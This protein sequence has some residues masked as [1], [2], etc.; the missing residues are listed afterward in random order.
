MQLKD[1]MWLINRNRYSRWAIRFES[2]SRAR[3][4]PQVVFDLTIQFFLFVFSI[5]IEFFLSSRLCNQQEAH[6][7]CS[8]LSMDS[9]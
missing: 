2:K 6:T 7:E 4:T 8:K 1:F 5:F 9:S 3:N